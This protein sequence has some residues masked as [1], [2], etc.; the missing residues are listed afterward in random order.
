[1]TQVI[2]VTPNPAID[3][4]TSVSEIVPFSKLRCTPARHHPGGGGI[5]VARVVTRL[6]GEA[7]AVYPA[8]GAAGQR[9]RQLLDREH[10]RSLSVPASEETREDVTVFEETTKRQYR[11]VLPGA[12]LTEP[13]WQDIL[14]LIASIEPRPRFVVASGSLPPGVPVD[15]FGRVARTAREMNAKVIVDSSG[16]PLK[17]ALEAGVYLIKPNRREFRELTGVTSDDDAVLIEAGRRLI[18]AGPV[19]V[20]ALTLGPSGALLI[21]RDRALRAAGLPIEPASV[22]GAGDSFVGAMVWS[23][24]RDDSLEAALKYGV[25]AGS[26]ALLSPGTELC[27]PADVLRLVPEVT[28]AVV[29]A[30]AGSQ[31]EAG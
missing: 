18:N 11:F 8:G 24:M 26:A 4:S 29:G 30:D 3:V 17:A 13:E 12:R 27:T 10:V 9:L 19:K 28:V 20:I 31:I 14:Q 25:A 15:F 16:P 2:T 21:T 1:L 22:V 5:N 23:L 6:G 7:T